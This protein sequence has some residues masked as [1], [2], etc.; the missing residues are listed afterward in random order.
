MRAYLYTGPDRNRA[1]NLLALSTGSLQQRTYF[2]VIGQPAEDLPLALHARSL[3]I[4]IV[5]IRLPGQGLC[6]GHADADEVA[7][8]TALAVLRQVIKSGDYR[9][10]ILDGIRQAMNLG[11]LAEEDVKTLVASAAEATEIAM[12]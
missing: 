6:R 1:A 4:D 11:L 7:I 9:L 8:H 5:R 2:A 10:V 3:P 12:T